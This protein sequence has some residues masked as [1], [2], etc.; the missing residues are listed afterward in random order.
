MFPPSPTRRTLRRNGALLAL[1]L[2]G[3]G[4]SPAPAEDRLG[5]HFGVVFPLV[6]HAHADTR[7]IGDDFQMGFPMGIT[8]K[9]NDTWA[10]DL[11][12][13]PGLDPDENGPIGVPL[14]VHPGV[15]RSLGGHWTAGLRLAFD[16]GGASWG[17]TPLLNRGL[18]SHYFVEAVVPV[19]FQ[20]DEHGE[21]STA[22]AFGIHLGV[23]F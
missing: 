16:I 19:R 12:L 22:V 7:D 8:V 11:E 15:L 20:D 4:P 5:G 21:G 18:G 6:T 1:A 14:T 9:T 23:G 2:L 3:L 17:F 13:V 10:F